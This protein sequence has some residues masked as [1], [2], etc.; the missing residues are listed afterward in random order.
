MRRVY[1]RVARVGEV[2][3]GQGRLIT[4]GAEGECVLFCTEDGHYYVTGALCPHQNEPLDRGRLEGCEVV[5]RRHHL[6]FDIR[7]GECTNAGGYSVRTLEVKVEG[8][9]IYVGCWED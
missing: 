3:S 7:T 8:D 1:H 4:A 5:C 2:P 6:R 9:D